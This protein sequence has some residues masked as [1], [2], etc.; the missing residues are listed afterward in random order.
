M[1]NNDRNR[2]PDNNASISLENLWPGYLQDGYFDKDGYLKS[3][4][5]RREKMTLF[6]ASIVA[7]RKVTPEDDFVK[8]KLTS[9]QLRR[10]FGHC[11]RIESRQIRLKAQLSGTET[12]PMSKDQEQKFL[13][14]AWKTVESDFLLIDPIAE[15]AK[16][17]GAAKLPL[18]FCEF[19]Q[20][21]IAT[22]KNSKDF[23]E[24]FMPHFE[25]FVGFSAKYLREKN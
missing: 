20:R 15:Y 11:R 23:K 22:V 2:P 25:A 14:Q 19:L 3:D 16:A 21:N 8:S 5:V 17:R 6:V 18:L 4:L 24:G 13:E 9:T 10:F 1:G 7:Q 12:N